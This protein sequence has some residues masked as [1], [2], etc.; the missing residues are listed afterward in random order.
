MNILDASKADFTKKTISNIGNLAT[1]IIVAVVD[2]ALAWL[3]FKLFSLGYI[4]IGIC[5][6]IIM[7]MI[8]VAFLVPKAHMFRWMS[9]GLSAWLLFSIFPI[10]YTIYNAFTNYGDGHLIT[11]AQAIE[12]IQAQTYLPE[13]GKAYEWIAYRSPDN[14][15]LLWLKDTEGNTKLVT[16][17]D[18]KGDAEIP[19]ETGKNG[20]GELDAQ[21]APLTIEGYQR[22]TPIQASQN[23]NLR[24]IKFGDPGNTVQVR[25]SSVAAELKPLYEYDPVANTF[26]DATTG[27]VYSDVKGTWTTKGGETIIPGYTAVIGI[28]NFIQFVNS[29][30]LRG[31]LVTIVIWNFMFATLSLFLT[32]SV[33]LLISIIYGDPKFKGKKILRS[34]LLIP[35]TIPSLITILIWRGMFNPDLGVINRILGS[36]FNIAPKWTTEPW[37]ARIALLVVNTWLGYPYWMLVTSGALQSIPSDIYEAAQIDGATGWQRFRSIT[38]P[39]LLVSVGPLMISSFIFNFNNFNLI[40]AFINGGPA[41]P[42]ATTQAGYTDIIISYVYNLAFASGR[43]VQYGYASAISLILFV[44]IAIMSLLQFRFTNMWEEVGENV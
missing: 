13:T 39:L 22:L 35:Y 29:P 17:V 38:L 11:Q 15:F 18:A 9:V 21:G 36:L 24:D 23:P 20:I 19:L 42:T 14:E 7:A 27:K 44:L 12:Q 8:S 34:L 5:M 6:V 30:G 41:I 3:A 37:L 25:S 31:P 2:V 10:I 1:I 32:F 43:G 33:G 40:Y 28:E 4:P 16:Q 26:T